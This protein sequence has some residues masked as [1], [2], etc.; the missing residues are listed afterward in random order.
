MTTE[1]RAGARKPRL[2]PFLF[3]SDTDFRFA[4][5]ILA[6]V[7]SSLYIYQS[8]YFYITNTNWLGRIGA[9]YAE[10]VVNQSAALAAHDRIMSQTYANN[11]GDF[12]STGT[13]GPL[14]Q[15]LFSIATPYDDCV[16]S[17]VLLQSAWMLGGVAAILLLAFGLYW[18]EPARKL[19][20]DRLQQLSAEDAPEVLQDLEELVRQAGLKRAPTFV[21]RPLDASSGGLAFGRAGRY[22]LALSGGLVSSFYID[23]RNFRAV[24][25]HELA[26]LKNADVDKTYFA[27]AAW[28]AFLILGLLPFLLT[29]PFRLVADLHHYGIYFGMTLFSVIVM[30][31]MV[32]L[33]RNS[34]LRA[35][36]AYADVRAS[37]WD[38]PQGGLADVLA[39]LPRP[40]RSFLKRILSVHPDPARRLLALRDTGRLMD[41][42]FW[43][44]FGVGLAATIAYGELDTFFM[45]ILPKGQENHSTLLTT[46][47]FAILVAAFTGLVVWRSAFAG[48][49][50]NDRQPRLWLLSLGLTLGL[51]LGPVVSLKSAVDALT[52]QMLTLNI[53]ASLGT[54]VLSALAYGTWILAFWGLTYLLLKWVGE[55]AIVWLA[56]LRTARGLWWACLSSLFV[57]GGILGY[58][59]GWFLM[60]REYSTILGW[61]R[62]L[63]TFGLYLMEG[64]VSPATLLIPLGLAALPLLAWIGRPGFE[65][66]IP[67]WAYLET[68]ETPMLPP[69]PARLHLGSVWLAASISA[70][71]YLLFL[72]VL[73]LLLRW[74]MPE[75]SRSLD[76][77]KTIFYYLTL[78]DA[79]LLQTAAALIVFT[80]ARDLRSE[81]AI[82][83]TLTGGLLMAMGFL[84]VNLL[85]GGM[86]DGSFLVGTINLSIK[87]GFG[88][89]LI[90]SLAGLLFL[91]VFSARVT[92]PA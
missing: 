70:G 69:A 65:R 80:N 14:A 53:F 82:L 72:L 56:R 61:P 12:L 45:N 49:V 46:P 40:P 41:V 23:P 76:L 57:Y 78:F 19:H 73:R 15:D 25:R 10:C 68:P 89:T 47:F 81:H 90:F 35:R 79:G 44:T 88:F 18:T 85:F 77:F 75:S 16:K 20:R 3:P 66:S 33:F 87:L 59:M 63:L 4:L 28:Q 62:G 29:R 13:Y 1:T 50:E 2:N 8:I 55:T 84:I 36:E 30:T 34:V 26:H 21:W 31:G 60:V 74:T 6:I 83:T 86:L 48:R 39:R 51:A 11:I 17:Y 91:R 7:C 92:R 71:M 38:G 32:Y 5:L 37:F 27:L 52:A 54:F 22:Y 58:F 9:T 24:V 64:L 42:D 43:T 67:G